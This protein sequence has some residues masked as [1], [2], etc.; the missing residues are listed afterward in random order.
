MHCFIKNATFLFP[1]FP[2]NVNLTLLNVLWERGVNYGLKTTLSH[3]YFI[4]NNI[5]VTVKTIGCWFDLHSRR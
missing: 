5:S 3:L 1:S 4:L 2:L